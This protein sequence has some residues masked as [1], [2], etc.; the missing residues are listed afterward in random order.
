M[1]GSYVLSPRERN[2]GIIIRMSARRTHEQLRES[3]AAYA[4]GAL[5]AEDRAVLEEHL[6]ECA[7]CRAE[8][9]AYRDVAASLAL[10]T[11][12]A[13]LP[14]QAQSDIRERLLDRARSSRQV[15]LPHARRVQPSERT[16]RSLTT[17]MGWLA[18]AAALVVAVA[19]GIAYQG[20]RA[21]V[22]RLEGQLAAAF[23]ASA[24]RDSA[25]LALFGPEVHVVSLSQPEQKP[26][27]RVFWNHTRNVFIVTAFDLTP[28]PA[29]KTYQLWAISKG[30]P[31]AS[32]GTFEPDAGGR[33]A[34]VL[35]VPEAIASAG[36]ID[37]CALTLE[38][39]GGSPQP[40]E[41]PRLLGS[42]RHTD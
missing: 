35:P 42:W 1:P 3:A 4:L 5:D 19:A 38:P 11:P 40:T 28:A 36:F 34:L 25:L 32:M 24:A 27:A 17:A 26:L 15:S 30:R 31:P 16:R 2:G 41:T 6:P 37:D 29:G 7:A 18:A 33:A 12:P 10:A 20:E 13:T 9:D 21:D 39:E 23:S 8:V 22:A 14:S